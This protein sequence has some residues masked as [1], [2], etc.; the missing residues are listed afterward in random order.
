M[1]PPV[2]FDVVR[3]FTTA[4]GRLGNE[5]AIVE[6]SAS[7]AG[8]EQVLARQLGFSETVFVDAFAGG[9]ATMRIFTPA[10]EI[11]FAGH[12]TVGT[13]WWLDQRGT[14]AA[15]LRVPAGE[16]RVRADGPLTWVRAQGTWTS[17]FDWQLLG[18]VAD[19]EAVDPA[20]FTDG[21]HYPYTWTDEPAGHLRSRM[22]SPAF[23]IT[24]DEAT[25]AAAVRLTWELGRDLTITQGRGSELFTHRLDGD[26]VEVGGRARFDRTVTV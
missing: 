10:V 8:R 14:P 5:L 12:P 6:S 24:E 19:V 16:V 17:V 13:A 11:P 4:E 18:S 7:T 20:R 22:F 2:T 23:G 3:V 1:H 26:W 9:V 25:G 21:H 15:T